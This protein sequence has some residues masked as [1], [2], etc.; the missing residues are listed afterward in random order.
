MTRLLAAVLVFV[1]PLAAAAAHG[2]VA[3]GAHWSGGHW[4]GGHWGGFHGGTRVVV[5]G[6]FFFGPFG[7]PYYPYAYPY[8]Y[9]YGYPYGGYPY[10]YPGYYPPAYYPPPPPPYDAGSAPPPE[11]SPPAEQGSTTEQPTPEDARRADYGL[12]SLRGV[13]DGAAVDLDGRF[14]LTAEALDQRWLALPRG[15]HTLTVRVGSG[16]PIER[17]VQVKSGVSQVVRFPKSAG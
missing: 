7:Y 2:G 5:G 4:G 17:R 3:G 1:T 15:T 10:G 13:P 9:G 11:S 16:L 14:W 6:G 12:V 8:G